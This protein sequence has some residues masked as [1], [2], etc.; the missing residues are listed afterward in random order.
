MKLY[1][2]NDNDLYAPL[3]YEKEFKERILNDKSYDHLE[4]LYNNINLPLPL[5]NMIMYKNKGIMTPTAKIINDLVNGKYTE[6]ENF[7]IKRY[8]RN[9]KSVQGYLVSVDRYYRSV[10]KWGH[11]LKINDYRDNRNIQ[12][13][14]MILEIEVV[15]YFESLNKAFNWTKQYSFNKITKNEIKT[16]LSLSDITWRTS[17]TKKR[18]IKALMSY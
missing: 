17:W 12:G 13:R 4:N 16:L 9:P 5:F 2:I 1:E 3:G 15:D 7:K 10:F 6:F 18:L 14:T 8:C 11:I